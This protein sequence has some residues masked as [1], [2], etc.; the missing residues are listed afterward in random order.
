[1]C[2]SLTCARLQTPLPPPIL[3]WGFEEGVCGCFSPQLEH[4]RVPCLYRIG[5]CC[6]NSLFFLPP[7]PSQVPVHLCPPQLPRPP[8][9]SAQASGSTASMLGW[10]QR[11]SLLKASG[12][13]NNQD[14]HYSLLFH[15]HC[16]CFCLQQNTTCPIS[17]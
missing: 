8:C 15:S 10:S 2:L 14:L 3:C 13:S 16:L 7:P 9:T 5:S 17:C 12:S 1:M 6:S 4:T 11:A